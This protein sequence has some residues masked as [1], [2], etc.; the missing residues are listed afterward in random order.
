MPPATPAGGQLRPTAIRNPIQL[1]VEGKDALNW[2]EA[3]AGHLSLDI[4]VQNF[5]GVT[6]FRRFL[7]AFTKMPG[8]ARVTSIGVV[9]DAE[10]SAADAFKSVR[11]ALDHSGLPVPTGT[12][13][14]ADGRP[15]VTVHILPD[16]R[17]SGM[18]ES[19][20]SESVRDTPVGGC[21]E[22]FLGCAERVAACEIGRPQKA[23]V[24]AFLSTR[25]DPHVSVGVAARKGYWDFG[26]P[27]LD[28]VRSFLSSLARSSAQ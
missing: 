21:I 24:H 1:L 28:G 15:G 12:D 17:S 18:L 6:E 19:L 4:Q 8:F 11:G 7:R 22:E 3:L 16:G 20:L 5:G 14:T 25:P 27:A 9:R 13:V 23:F 26:H 2:F 10:E